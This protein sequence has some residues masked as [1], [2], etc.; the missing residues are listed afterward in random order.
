MLA[1]FN[2]TKARFIEIIIKPTSIYIYIYLP[3]SRLGVIPRTRK[4]NPIY[5]NDDPKQRALNNTV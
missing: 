4:K 3:L 1:Y 2:D 5:S